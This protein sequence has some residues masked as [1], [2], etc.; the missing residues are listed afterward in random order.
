MLSPKQ[1]ASRKSA[2]KKD[3]AN[4]SASPVILEQQI[5]MFQQDLAFSQGLLSKASV[6][7][8]LQ[9][10]IA[11]FQERIA[12]RLNFLRQLKGM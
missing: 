7:N 6:P 11:F 3:R 4:L 5:K 8:N 9:E 10:D 12:L 2:L 1:I